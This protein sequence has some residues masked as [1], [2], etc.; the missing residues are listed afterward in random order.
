[1]DTEKYGALQALVTKY[2]DQNAYPRM[3][4]TG[5]T[6]DYIIVAKRPDVNLQLGI[7]PLFGANGHQTTVGL[8]LR[9][10]PI[11][12]ATVHA[13]GE[14]GSVSQGYPSTGWDFPWEKVSEERASLVRTFT[15]NRSPDDIEF[16]WEDLKEHRFYGKVLSFLLEKVEAEHLEVASEEIGEFFNACL[17]PAVLATQAQSDPEAGLMLVDAQQDIVAGQ[18]SAKK[19]ELEAKLKTGAKKTK[20]DKVY[21]PVA[22]SASLGTEANVS[23]MLLQGLSPDLNANGASEALNDLAAE[24]LGDFDENDGDGGEWNT[25]GDD[26]PSVA[27]ADIGEPDDA[28]GF[29]GLILPDSDPNKDE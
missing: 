15:F 25:E 19:A 7:K 12:G 5:G 6:M 26:D 23:A 10:A 20:K 11:P 13:F 18:L 22:A 17:F 14:T 8:R 3:I 28:V 24:A 9:S 1:M 27:D 16:L 4:G 29:G 21:E 2:A